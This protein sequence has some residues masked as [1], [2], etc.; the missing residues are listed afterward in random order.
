M[1]RIL[2]LIFVLLSLGGVVSYFAVP[3]N[4]VA[5]Q[6]ITAF[7][8]SRGLENISFKID[9]V[10]LHQATF[11]SIQIGK[12][13]P[14]LLQSVTVQYR[15][16]EMMNGNIQDIV[17]T[18][19]NIQILQTKEGWKISGLEDFKSSKSPREVSPTLSNIIDLLPFSIV[20]VKDSYLHISGET[21]Q[22]SLPFSMRL[23]KNSKTVLDMTINAT[24]FKTASLQASS[25][26]ITLKAEPD[27]NHN[28]KGVWH[29]ESLDLGEAMPIPVLEGN[30]TLA[31]AG[32]IV[33]IDGT[34]VSAD[35]SYNA[36]FSSLI[37]I[38]ASEKNVLTVK[39]AAFPFKKGFIFAKDTRIPFE[40]NK[41]ITVTLD[42]RKVSL[43]DLMQTLT[44][45][46][47]TATGT[48]SGRLP[49][50][51]KPD[52]SYTLG[53]GTLKAD[54]N[55]LLQMPGEAIPGDNE[56]T[57]LVREILKNLHYSLFSAAVDTSGADG[58]VVRLSLEGNNPDIYNGRIVKL[59]V[60]LTGDVLDFIQ[61]NA[62]LFTNPGKLLEQG[63]Q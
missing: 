54:S 44:G 55:G 36:A 63:T 60:N 26:I 45:Q 22:T 29:L 52:G 58:M 9:N 8:K 1:K 4:I 38:K 2:L 24:N 43:N 28:W 41:N 27:E 11:N 40:R 50:I 59:N 56:K 61:Q 53:K 57:Q 5:E 32:D 21:L 18:G 23:T 16:R 35:K 20:N 3:W 39:S 37:D 47:V 17:L 6:R 62:T 13:N 14:L 31:N 19:L 51:L 33:T 30:G 48:V 25:G 42:I 10:G 15:P 34:I 12:E 46:K 49:V 7:L